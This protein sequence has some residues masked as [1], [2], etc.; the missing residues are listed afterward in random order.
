MIKSFNEMLA[1][2]QKGGYAIGAFNTSNLEI[3]LAIA[4]AAAKLKAPVIIQTSES[5][6][7]Y[8]NLPTLYNM[9]K[10]VA[11]TVA[12]KA[13][14]AIHLDHGKDLSII[15]EC[16]KIGYSSVHIDA[17]EK[18]FA[19]NVRLSQKVQRLGKKAHCLVQAELG[20]ILGKEGLIRLEK[21]EINMEELM[22]DPEQAQK[23]VKL[24]KV[25]TLAISV[26]TI[27]GRFVGIEKVDQVRL[28][29]IYSLVKIPLVLHGASGLTPRD[30]KEAVAN[31]VRIVNIDTNLRVAFKKALWKSMSHEKSMV[32]PRAIL[33]PS[34]EAMQAEVE[35]IIKILGSANKA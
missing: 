14:V 21:G 20:S 17:S 30:L 27:H 1:K 9:I 32:D 26:G 6:I 8:S 34:T 19:T 22:T 10:N 12:G 29:K 3:T 18:D 15:Q 28:K 2:A 7:K 13:P 31:G 25:D 11:E 16:I 24:T 23:F 4:R 5:A 33:R 35:R